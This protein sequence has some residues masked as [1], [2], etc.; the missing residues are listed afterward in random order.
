MTMMDEYLAGNP[1][2]PSPVGTGGSHH[3][4][5]TPLYEAC[6]IDQL[7][8]CPGFRDPWT[9]SQLFSA[10]CFRNNIKSLTPQ[11]KTFYDKY[12]LNRHFVLG[13]FVSSSILVLASGVLSVLT[14]CCCVACCARAILRR[15]CQQKCRWRRMAAQQ[16][17][18][19]QD[20][21]ELE[22]VLV[23][24]INY[25]PLSQEEAALPLPQFVF[26]PGQFPQNPQI[27]TPYPTQYIPVYVAE[28]QQPQ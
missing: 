15:R 14:V 24:S 11:C 8:V 7:R 19:K 3:A 12:V 1:D 23:Q 20:K 21:T 16:K 10:S 5:G 26:A 27:F 6:K 4:V 28:E 9:E 13:I 18:A 17:L 22:P 25:D 2:S